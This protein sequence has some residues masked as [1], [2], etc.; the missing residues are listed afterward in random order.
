M[1]MQTDNGIIDKVKNEIEKILDGDNLK[2]AL[3]F[4]S[5]M[6]EIGMVLE[7]D[8]HPTFTYRGEWVC[9]LVYPK[10]GTEPPYFG[11]CSWP[12]E[13]DVIESNNFL[14]EENLKIY[15]QENVK[16]CFNCG[17]CKESNYPGPLTKNIFGKKYDNVCCN[18]FHFFNLDCEE[19]ENAKKLM[20]LLKHII[21]DMKMGS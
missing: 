12:G 7:M 17:G 15:A 14:I 3:D 8:Y 13:L 21:E 20:E 6:T 18:A 4:I 16:I 10:A 5:Y 1:L 11:I 2:Y 9:L 19:I